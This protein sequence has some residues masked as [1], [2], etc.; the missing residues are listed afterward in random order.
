MKLLWT[1]SAKKKQSAW[2]YSF[3]R[4]ERNVVSCI[5]S[6]ERIIETGKTTGKTKTGRRMLTAR[7]LQPSILMKQKNLLVR[8]VKKEKGFLIIDIIYRGITKEELDLYKKIGVDE[9]FVFGTGL[10]SHTSFLLA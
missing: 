2:G 6:G 3:D 10:P 9:D 8:F 5:E 4:V 1:K 7:E